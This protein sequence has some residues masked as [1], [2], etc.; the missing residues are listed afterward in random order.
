MWCLQ[1]LDVLK[2][3]NWTNNNGITSGFEVESWRHTTH[4]T[5]PSH[6]E[7]LAVHTALA[8]SVYAKVPCSN[9][10]WNI[11]WSFLP[12]ICIVLEAVSQTPR[13]A[14]SRVGAHSS[15]LWPYTGNW[16]KSRGWAPFHKWA[17]FREIMVYVLHRRHWMLLAAIQYEPLELCWGLTRNFTL[18]QEKIHA[19]WFL[20][21]TLWMPFS[22]LTLFFLMPSNMCHFTAEAITQFIVWRSLCGHT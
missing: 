14:H 13:E 12:Q 22:I 8:T 6:R 17:F 19:E 2:A 7:H 16:A 15:I 5:A 21:M 10:Q 1:Q 4:W 9:I 11:T 18:H 3:N 20:C